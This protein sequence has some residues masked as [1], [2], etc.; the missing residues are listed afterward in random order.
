M[1]LSFN[2]ETVDSADVDACSLELAR[3]VASKKTCFATKALFLCE[4]PPSKRK[5]LGCKVRDD[6]ET[7][8]V[9]WTSD[10]GY[11]MDL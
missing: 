2:F 8:L 3:L 11:E 4:A 9:G 1:V 10:K 5:S 6:L 7:F